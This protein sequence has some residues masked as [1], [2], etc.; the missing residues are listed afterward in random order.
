MLGLSFALR[1]EILTCLVL[2]SE[3]GSVCK[4]I[5]RLRIDTDEQRIIS[6]SL[7]YTACNPLNPK[8][9]PFHFLDQPRGAPKKRWRNVI[10]KDLGEV[11]ATAEDANQIMFKGEV[12][13]LLCA[14]LFCV[15]N[16]AQ[17]QDLCF[18][19]P[20]KCKRAC[21]L[22]IENIGCVEV[23]LGDPFKEVKE[24]EMLPKKEKSGRGK[25]NPGDEGVTAGININPTGHQGTQWKGAKVMEIGEGVKLYY[26][27][28][29]PKR[30]GLAIAI[31]ESHKDFVSAVNKINDRI[32][33]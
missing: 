13:L 14:F 20:A 32:M 9:N 10:K 21:W 6:I 30:N 29:E 19:G 16:I 25:R 2:P 24:E 23:K 3:G 27:V 8:S 26:N 5:I 11:T 1:T 4:V 31:A 33:V 18:W 22:Q 28:V 12:I 15:M 7:F 17:A